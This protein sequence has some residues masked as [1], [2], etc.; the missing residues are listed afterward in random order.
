MIRTTRRVPKRVHRRDVAVR[1]VV[2]LWVAPRAVEVPHGHVEK[3]RLGRLARPVRRAQ[4]RL[5][6][7]RR[8]AVVKFVALHLLAP[9]RLRLEPEHIHARRK[10]VHVHARP[11]PAA[12]PA[13]WTHRA[14]CAPVRR[15]AP[16][17]AT[18]T[19][20]MAAALRQAAGFARAVLRPVLDR[21]LARLAAKALVAQAAAP[22][23]QSAARAL[24]GAARERVTHAGGAHTRR[25]RTLALRVDARRLVAKPRARVVVDADALRDDRN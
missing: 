1:P 11:L 7:E 24:H 4:Q 12:G 5:V 8:C 20:A 21:R 19:L 6:H 18:L 14:I 9:E 2:D 10:L 17:E 25:D 3:V 16:A 23:T 22:R 13:R 15:R